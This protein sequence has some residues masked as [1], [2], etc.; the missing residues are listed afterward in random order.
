MA[1]SGR[2]SGRSTVRPA[3]VLD[4]FAVEI[5]GHGSSGPMA[6]ERYV[7][8]AADGVERCVNEAGFDFYTPATTVGDAGPLRR[9]GLRQFDERGRRQTRSRS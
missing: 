3:T 7:A 1:A 9:P 2:P 4:V 6:D 8:Y 5:L